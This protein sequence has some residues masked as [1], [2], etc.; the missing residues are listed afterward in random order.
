MAQATAMK[1]APGAAGRTVQGT[2]S[3]FGSAREKPTFHAQEHARDNWT[4]DIRTVTFHDARSW[5]TPP[6][7]D[8]EGVCLAPAPSAIKS[9]EDRE[10]VGAKYKGELE[11]ILRS[12]LGTAKIAKIVGM[13]GGNMR[14][15]PRTDRYKTGMNSQPAHFPH[16]DCTMRTATGLVDHPRWGI[17]REVLK[18]GQRLVGYNVWRVV[19]QPPQDWPLAAADV[20]TVA[21]GDLVLADG[22]YD[23]G[24]EPWARGEA[25]LV[26]YNPA[27]R[28]IYFSN[29][30][31]DEALVFRAY[32]DHDRGYPG[33]PHVAFEDPSAPPEA[34]RIS[35]EAR[36][37][38][39]F[40]E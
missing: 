4:P 38:A 26:K 23:T 7:L 31:P 21:W 15:S 30:R 3:Y 2:I 32:E 14:F 13:R 29:M 40:D 20:R 5:A 24:P 34:K 27:H 39:I 9:F 28:W 35:V 36:V 22:V 16:V 19:S 12:Q 37:Y 18:P 11:E 25:W 33:A 17:R 1:E 8:R 10:E 6:R